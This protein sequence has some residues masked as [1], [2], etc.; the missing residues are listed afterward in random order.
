MKI[1]GVS[2]LLILLV[3]ACV[4]LGFLWG[5]QK[6]N[7]KHPPK[8]KEQTEHVIQKIEP[9]PQD[10]KNKKES[11]NTNDKKVSSKK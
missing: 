10:I 7:V 9:F 1:W 11:Q 5:V 8:S 2:I 3:G 4:G 6:N